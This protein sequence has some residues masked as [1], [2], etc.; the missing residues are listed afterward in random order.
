[1]SATTTNQEI[2]MMITGAEF[3]L[4]QMQPAA[5]ISVRPSRP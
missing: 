1:V 3:M 2:D 5:A 4:Q